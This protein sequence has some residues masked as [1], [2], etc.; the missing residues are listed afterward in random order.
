MCYD[1]D[2][3]TVVSSLDRISNRLKILERNQR[4]ILTLLSPKTIKLSSLIQ[5]TIWSAFG[6]VFV[7]NIYKNTN[8]ETVTQK[9]VTPHKTKNSVG[10]LP[11]M[12]ISVTRDVDI[13]D[14]ECPFIEIN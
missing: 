13:S 7:W 2:I 11:M 14:I 1:C 9:T 12:D 5:L 4:H 6:I 8:I 3:R 10:T